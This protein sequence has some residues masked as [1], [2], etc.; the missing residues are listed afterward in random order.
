VDRR[1]SRPV[2]VGQVTIGGEAPIAIQSMTNT[3]TSDAEATVAQIL[4]LEAAG[5][6]IVRAS[7]YDEACVA[8]IPAI[9]TAIHIP[10]VA[11]IHFNASLAIGAIRAGVDKLRLNPG[12]IGSAERVE[13]V[14]HEARERGIP[15]RVGVNSG[16]LDKEMLNR[17]GNTAR[18]LA[19][20]ALSEVRQLEKAGF[21]DIVIAVK[22]SDPARTVEA[23][24]LIASLCDYPLHI[25]VTESGTPEIG[26]VKSAVGVGALL[27]D[28]IGDTVRISL[29]GSPIPEVAAAKDI[30]QASGRRV[31]GPEIVSCPTC[32]RCG[33][34]VEGIASRVREAARK[35]D[36]PLKI[37]VM[38][39]VVNGPGEAK[40]AD[41]GLAGGK[42][43]GMVFQKGCEPLKLP[44]EQLEAELIARM[45]TIS[46]K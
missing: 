40:D 28:G 31:F 37:A 8:A 39:C 14:A 36:R 33:I 29:S 2:R 25:G 22:G 41:L 16:S 38:G 32:G 21:E 12:N 1:K 34:D 20:S 35:I 46:G 43:Y 11:D 42:E 24:R 27:L 6:E 26:R 3:E 15:I 7:V 4:A 19:E 13:R 10:L 30:L 44:K 5:C 23:N 9:K 17:Y 18:A 45:V